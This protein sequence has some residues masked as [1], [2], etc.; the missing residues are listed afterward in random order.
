MW[1]VCGRGKERLQ[2]GG[3][4]KETVK[5]PGIRKRPAVVQKKG[6]TGNPI[7]REQCEVR[8]HLQRRKKGKAEAYGEKRS[9]S[10]REEKGE[11][12]V[13]DEAL[14]LAKAAMKAQVQPTENT[15]GGGTSRLRGKGSV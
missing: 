9:A 12:G 13:E 15:T 10:Y 8:E 3:K 14:S 11:K 2:R 4:K 7:F 5:I 1:K 6:R